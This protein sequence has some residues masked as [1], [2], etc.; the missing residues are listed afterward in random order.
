MDSTGRTRRAIAEGFIP[1]YSMAGADRALIS[2]EAACILNVNDQ[3]AHIPIT[4]Y[5]VDREPVGPYR[6]EVPAR[7][8]LHLR[9]NELNDP[10]PS[11]STM[12][13]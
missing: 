6:V 9:F 4:I 11:R 1:P 7:R 13:Q 2:H 12:L 8:T 3:V 10:E 5:F